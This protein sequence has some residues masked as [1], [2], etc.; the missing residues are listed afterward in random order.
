MYE[1]AQKE[2]IKIE[3]M[4]Y[5]I[6]G[7]QVMIDSDLADLYETE[8]KR[9]NE[10]VRRNLKKFPERFSWILTEED[11][12]NLRSQFATSNQEN[13]H[14]GRRYK[15]RV[16]TE[17]GITM[18]ATVLK[19]DVAINV[20]IAIMD[21]FAAMRK[22]ISNN[23]IEQKYYHD[24]IIRHDSE[25]KILQETLSNFKEKN[26]HIFFEGQIYDA[27]SIMINIFNT[28]ENSIFIIDN[29]IDKNILDVLSKTN[30]NITLITS[31]YNNNDYTKYQEQYHNIKLEINNKIH[32]RFIIIDNKL[33]YHCGASFKDL[34]KKCFAITKIDDNDI[35][36]NLL[37][38][39]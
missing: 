12:Q 1:I 28:S 21:A 5:N 18:L 2:S 31:K 30:K 14:G 15:T 10:V 33:L 9:I 29:Y 23:L 6:R 32:D 13:N 36:N 35:L 11:L 16:F 37:K 3:N 39:I 4:V 8:T 17:Q 34:G 19:T 38:N 22:Y 7:Q 24:M 26:S 20:T 27:Y 25:I